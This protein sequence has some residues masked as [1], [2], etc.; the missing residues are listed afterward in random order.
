[1]FGILW[2][3]VYDNVFQFPPISSSFAQPLKKSETT[4][5]VSQINSLVNSM[6][7]CVAL[8]EANGGHKI[9]TSFLVNGPTFSPPLVVTIFSHRSNSPTCSEEAKVESC[10]PRNMIRLAE[11]LFNTLLD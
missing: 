2:I 4:F 5:H 6:R 1:M 8:D 7:R 11:L 3:Y 10:V 9:L